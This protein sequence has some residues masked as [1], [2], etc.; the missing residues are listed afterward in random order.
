MNP[1]PILKSRIPT[2]TQSI[3]DCLAVQT[4]RKAIQAM[5]HR[6]KADRFEAV[7]S[8]VTTISMIVRIRVE[9]FQE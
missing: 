6:C 5:V 3:A 9:S 8:A 1:I 4:K 2:T 7:P